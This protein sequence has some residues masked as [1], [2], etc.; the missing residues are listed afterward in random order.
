[1][2]REVRSG[3]SEGDLRYHFDRLFFHFSISPFS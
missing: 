2:D 3:P 1:M